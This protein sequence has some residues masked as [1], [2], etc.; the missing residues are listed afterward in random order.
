MLP[1]ARC[2]SPQILW[3]SCAYTRSS[4]RGRPSTGRYRDA[5]RSC[6]VKTDGR[7][8]VSQ[9]SQHRMYRS[10]YLSPDCPTV[11]LGQSDRRR[12]LT[13]VPHSSAVAS[14]RYYDR[15][16]LSIACTSLVATVHRRTGFKSL[17]QI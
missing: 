7:R 8:Q 2:A 16:P 4:N 5:V 1:S 13:V 11:L 9:N 17:R 15:P 14:E 3:Y 6:A 10:I 12:Y